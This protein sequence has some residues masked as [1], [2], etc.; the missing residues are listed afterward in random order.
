MNFFKKH[1]VLIVILSI[2]IGIII[3]VVSNAST[4][5]DFE[6]A[7][8]NPGE[9]FHIIGKLN[10]DK[11]ADVVVTPD[12]RYFVFYM[13]DKNNKENV[14]VF[15]GEKPQDFE[16][17]DQVVIIGSMKDSSFMATDLLLKCPSKY[18]KK[19]FNTEE[20]FKSDK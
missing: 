1:V 12:A 14:V 15:N 17:S 10:I 19:G 20:K 3:G 2:G 4:Y 18:D 9:E 7:L 13:F 11:P 5:S 6:E 8:Q 16:K